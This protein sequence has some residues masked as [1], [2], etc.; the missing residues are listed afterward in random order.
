LVQRPQGGAVKV[1]EYWLNEGQAILL[2]TKMNTGQ[3]KDATFDVISVYMAWRHGHL[4][5]QVDPTPGIVSAVTGAI[6]PLV[7]S[8][9]E[10]ISLH[11]Q[12][13]QPQTPTE[14][15]QHNARQRACHAS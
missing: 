6:T 12:Q 3:G 8:I 10:L 13:M 7:D 2:F 5:Q 1:Q 9:R 11:K 4:P 14:F 15:H